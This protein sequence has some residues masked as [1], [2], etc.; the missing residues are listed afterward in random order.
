MSDEF[1]ELTEMYKHFKKIIWMINLC[2][3]FSNNAV[4]VL[5]EML[6]FNLKLTLNLKAIEITR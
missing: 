1:S 3:L 5:V 6:K 2:R 4:E